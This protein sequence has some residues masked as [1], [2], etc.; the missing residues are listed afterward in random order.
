[1]ALLVQT[2]ADGLASVFAASSD[3]AEAASSWADAYSTY[4]QAATA[5]VAIPVFTG[6][7]EGLLASNLAA[8]FAAGVA[9]EGS[10][11]LA[12]MEVAF[13]AYWLVPPVVF[14][15]GVVTVAPPG[16]AALLTAAIPAL[17]VATTSAMAAGIFATAIDAW[18][19]TVIVTFAGV[20][21]VTLL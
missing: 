1:M 7:E 15:A 18:T 6:L 20:V 19:H 12:A 13:Q 4:A 17:L 21:T 2:L 10:T 5:G 11:T 8:A 9:S 3:F 14:G 16:L